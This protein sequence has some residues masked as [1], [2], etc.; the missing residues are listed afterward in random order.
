[1]KNEEWESWILGM[2]GNGY[3]PNR[4]TMQGF[5]LNLLVEVC[6]CEESVLKKK[7][8]LNLIKLLTTKTNSQDIIKIG[9]DW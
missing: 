9:E 8:S 1:M 3:L 5:I 4:K 2:T 7:S 6:T